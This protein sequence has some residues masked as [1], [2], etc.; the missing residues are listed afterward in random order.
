MVRRK[1]LYL[2]SWNLNFTSIWSVPFYYKDFTNKSAKK[3]CPNKVREAPFPKIFNNFFTHYIS[4][5][6]LK[7]VPS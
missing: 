6:V 2:F 1:K 7:I 3:S 5:I 4:F